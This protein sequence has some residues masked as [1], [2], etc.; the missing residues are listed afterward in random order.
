MPC[1]WVVRSGA[2]VAGVLFVETIEEVGM[3]AGAMEVASLVGGGSGGAAVTQAKSKPSVNTMI[4]NRI[5]TFK[6]SSFHTCRMFILDFL[7]FSHLICR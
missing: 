7:D 3:S 2:G 5:C 4:V 6:R 1:G